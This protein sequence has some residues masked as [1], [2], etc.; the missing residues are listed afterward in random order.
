[1]ELLDDYLSKPLIEEVKLAFTSDQCQWFYDEESGVY[2]HRVYGDDVPTSD[3]FQ[4]IDQIFRRR[5]NATSWVDIKIQAYTA[6]QVLP[7]P[8]LKGKYTCFFYF[9]TTDGITSVQ[10]ESGH[11]TIEV[12]ENRVVEVETDEYTHTTYDEGP[13]RSLLLTLSYF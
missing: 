1:M 9:D 11:E 8:D 4:M 5:L 3:R 10:T 6:G 13:T 12:K 7:T 2:T